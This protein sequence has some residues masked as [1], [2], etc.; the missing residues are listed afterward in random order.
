MTITAR[1]ARASGFQK[2]YN[3]KPHP[4]MR[5]QTCQLTNQ[6]QPPKIP[7]NCAGELRTGRPEAYCK[8]QNLRNLDYGFPN[9]ILFPSAPGKDFLNHRRQTAPQKFLR[10][11]KA[12]RTYPGHYTWLKF[13]G[14]FI[15]PPLKV[16]ISTPLLK[17]T[18]A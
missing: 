12:S 6:R 14:T 5:Q 13:Q 18:L 7:C 8:V 4:R 9:L 10:G 17:Y 3:K 1:V 15:Y 16:K 2:P 11:S